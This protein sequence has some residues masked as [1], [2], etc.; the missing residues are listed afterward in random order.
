MTIHELKSTMPQRGRVMALSYRPQRKEPIV[1][2]DQLVLDPLSGIAQDHYSKQGGSRMITLIQQEH[3]M[4][5][6]SILQREVSIKDVRRN[7]LVEGINLLALHDAVF[8]LGD[9]IL[10]GTGY[11]QPCSRMETILGSGGYNAMRGHG[12]ITAKVLKGGIVYL[13][14]RVALKTVDEH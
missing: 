7:I 1:L 8:Q 14:S 4:A 6:S 12:G 3:L 5:V 9:A 13:G 10:Q 2:V 11:C